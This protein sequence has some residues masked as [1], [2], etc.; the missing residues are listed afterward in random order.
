VYDE[1][2]PP[3]HKPVRRR[4]PD[5]APRSL[6]G[7]YGLQDFYY[8]DLSRSLR[9]EIPWRQPRQALFEL[10][11]FERV[12]ARCPD[13]IGAM[14]ALGHLYTRLGEHQKGLAVD[15]RLVQLR[16]DR[17]VAHY[18]LACSLALTGRLDQAFAAL[19]RAVRLGYGDFEHL[20]RDPDLEALRADPRYRKFLR[21]VAAGKL[22]A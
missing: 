21:A 10:N 1:L 9:R 12:L 22:N 7:G 13:H 5:A 6:L 4:K 14:E 20:A 3:K 19:D 18:N 17:P 8:R 16:P 11:F 2:G 15:Q